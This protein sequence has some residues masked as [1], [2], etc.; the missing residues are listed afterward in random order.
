MES[1]ASFAQCVADNAFPR[2]QR[3]AVWVLLAVLFAADASAFAQ[4][5][6]TAARPT[7]SSSAWHRLTPE[8]F[9]RLPEAQRRIDPA[10][11]DR[12][13]LGAA[14]FHATNRVRRQLGLPAFTHLPQ[15]DKAADVKAAVG[16]LESEL[17]HESNLPFNATPAERVT[18]AGLNYSMVAENI[19]RQPS[20]E[21]APGENQVAVRRVNGR[22]EFFHR[23]TKR[24][25]ERRTYADLGDKLVAA[26]MNS[27]GH[28][29][30]IVSPELKSLGCAARPCESVVNRHEQ[31]YAVQVFFT[32]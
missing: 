4:S 32:P 24:R 13:L 17:S 8:A 23:G 31:V 11:F 18:T 7:A 14:I 21:L 9:A 29:A 2:R 19:A 10:K 30:N 3:W 25:V 22:D 26:W 20:Y 1:L 5:S 28:R 15:L 6:T 16:V 12:A 27:P